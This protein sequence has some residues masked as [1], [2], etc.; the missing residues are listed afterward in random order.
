[1]TTGEVVF[2]DE[3]SSIQTEV[4]R[5]E[6]AGVD[7]IIALGHGGYNLDQRIAREVAGIDLVIGGHTNTFLYTG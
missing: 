1:M 7:M 6:E 3:I 5:L 4:R 2:L